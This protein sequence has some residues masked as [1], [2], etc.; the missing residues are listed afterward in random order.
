MPIHPR[1]LP[2]LKAL[3]RPRSEWFFTAPPSREFPAGD[4]HVNPRDENEWF[5]ALA[6]RCGFTVKRENGGLTLHALRRFFKTHCLNAGV[7]KPLVD[8][9]MG[10]VDSKSMDAFYYDCTP[11]AARAWMAK[12][13]FGP[14]SE[15]DPARLTV[16]PEDEGKSDPRQGSE[17]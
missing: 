5:Q 12:V 8:A 16:T 15:A 9:W 13:N 3:K 4:H 14:P 11:D 7:P 1:L 10:H 17:K 6:K 2:I